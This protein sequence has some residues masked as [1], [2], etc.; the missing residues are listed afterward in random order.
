M[1]TAIYLWKFKPKETKPCPRSA[2][3]KNSSFIPHHKIV[4]PK[5]IRKLVGRYSKE[6]E[7]LWDNIPHWIIKCDVGRLLYLYFN[8]G[9]YMDIDCFL[10][11]HLPP[12]LRGERGKNKV[13]LFIENRVALEHLGPREIRKP[14]FQLRIANYII[15]VG[16]VKHPFIKKI[17]DEGIRRLKIILKDQQKVGDKVPI[18]DI[19]WIFGPDLVTTMYH[20]VG[21]TSPSVNLLGRNWVKHC[22]M[23]SWKTESEKNKGQAYLEKIRK[24][25]EKL[26]GKKLP[27]REGLRKAMAFGSKKRRVKNASKKKL[28]S[29]EAHGKVEGEVD[30][31]EEGE[32]DEEEEGEVDEEEKGEAD[33]EEEGG[34]NEEGEGEVEEEEG[35]ANEEEEGEANEKEEGEANE[36]EEGGAAEEE[37]GGAAEE[38]EGVVEKN[39]DKEEGVAAG[40]S[41]EE[42]DALDHEIA[43]AQEAVTVA[44]YSSDDTSLGELKKAEKLIK[45][46]EA[47]KSKIIA[48]FFA[49]ERK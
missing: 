6:L 5:S 10:K 19:L 15:G 45:T 35:E 39:D 44:L 14:A 3:D 16:K 13:V 43:K 24:K 18:T 34:A 38:E 49:D 28:P 33:E 31:E 4:G 42:V 8:G 25:V 22:C 46:L 32:V 9:L 21:H 27:G 23:N 29:E 40:I 11:K 37:E 47:K 30:E 20:E 1:N 2:I 12:R 41:R 48:I 17:L 7:D 36:K 26:T